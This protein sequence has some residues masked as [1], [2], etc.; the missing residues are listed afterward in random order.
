MAPVW[1][2]GNNSNPGIVPPNASP[3]GHTY[4]E[5]N[6]LWWRWFLALP[7]SNN[8][9]LGADC[10]TGQVG[11]VWFL[12][13][14]PGPATINCNV[15]PGKTLFLPVI[16][17]E[18]SSLE[19]PPFFGATPADRTACA[20][21]IGDTGVNLS[22]TIDGV[23]VQNLANY[24]STS[25]NFTFVVPPN[26]VLGTPAGAGESVA[27]GFY[28]MITPLSHGTHI[29]HIG[30]AYLNPAFAID[31]TIVLNVGR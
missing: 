12:V 2:Q 22:A 25:P 19:P 26:N 23:A 7:I 20:K 14:I 5:W 4:A 30:G 3:H 10:S 8:P 9:A 16:N 15:P 13:G 11:S 29:I 1:A 18:C 6:A 27:D 17:T 31:T 24:R 21:A 28:L